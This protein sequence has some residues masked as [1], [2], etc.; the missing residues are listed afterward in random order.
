VFKREDAGRRSTQISLRLTKHNAMQPSPS[1]RP[2]TFVAEANRVAGHLHVV[3]IT[4]GSVASVK[5]PLIVSE[6]LQVA[7]SS[8]VLLWLYDL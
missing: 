3:L 7:R 5:A 6:L 2:K 1:E 4:T 8:L